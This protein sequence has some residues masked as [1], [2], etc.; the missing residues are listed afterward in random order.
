MK[1]KLKNIM[2]KIKKPK[3]VVNYAAIKR[4]LILRDTGLDGRFT[5]KVVKENKHKKEKYKN[6]WLDDL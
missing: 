1:I 5:T 2:G 4:N 6:K 3:K